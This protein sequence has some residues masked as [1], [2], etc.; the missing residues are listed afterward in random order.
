MRNTAKSILTTI[1]TKTIMSNT[2]DFLFIEFP[3]IFRVEQ[4]ILNNI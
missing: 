2:F 3:L 4:G 1:P